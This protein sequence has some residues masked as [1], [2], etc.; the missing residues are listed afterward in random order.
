MQVK[1]QMIFLNKNLLI[2]FYYPI[3]TKFHPLQ[4][5]HT[6]IMKLIDSIK[7]SGKIKSE[8]KWEKRCEDRD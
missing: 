8:R 1:K 2:I 6:S 7:L 5:V 4:L 3:P